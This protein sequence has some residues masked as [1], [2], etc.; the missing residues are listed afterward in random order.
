MS[1]KF[2]I[3]G[4]SNI[5]RHMNPTNCRDRP[6]MSGAQT[7]PCGKVSLLAEALRS[8]R[9]E[10]SVILL[11][12]LTNFLTSSEA[13]GASL[14]LRIDPVLLEV[15]Q[16][17]FD[18]ASQ[19]TE[20]YFII[21]P[22]MYRLSPL[23]YRDGLPQILTKCSEAF[24]S[25]PKNVLMMSSFSTPELE[26]DGV[27]LTAYSGME[28]VL[29]LFDSANKLLESL[30]LP[31]SKVTELASEDTRLLQD[32]MVAIEQDHRRLSKFVD[33][34]SAEDSELAD[35]HENVRLESSFMITGLQSLGDKLSPK[36]WQGQAIKDVQ[37]VILALLG[38]ERPIRFIQNKT[39]QGKDP[40]IRYMVEMVKIE[41]SKEIRNTFGVFFVGGGDKR[42]DTLKHVSISSNVTPATS[43]RIAILKIFGKRYLASNPGAKVQVRRSFPVC[44]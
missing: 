24:K 31:S 34:K 23:W 40:I 29:F 22:P 43:V 6:L 21:A 4:D 5:K 27:H 41:D 8:V 9:K 28:F 19:D 10:S 26:A 11:S 33:T 3:L 35:F 42:P 18:A 30:S 1:H 2:S 7:I 13:A 16:M 36:E 37:G 25:R 32:R 44:F 15:A 20:R 38:Q 39:S 12:C 14:S 17:I